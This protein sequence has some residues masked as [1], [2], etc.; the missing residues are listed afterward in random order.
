[1]RKLKCSLSPPETI[2]NQPRK[3][4]S[5][6]TLSAA[7]A[8]LATPMW[9]LFH[10]ITTILELSCTLTIKGPSKT[11]RTRPSW[12]WVPC[13]PLRTSPRLPTNMVQKKLSVATEPTPWPGRGRSNS[14]RTRCQPRSRARQF[15]SKTVPRWMWTTSSSAL[16]TSSTT[17]SWSKKF[18]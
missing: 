8:I 3:S 13:F 5:S 14:R 11:T 10:A 2:L 1:M 7:L 9:R 16:A 12:S 4:N 6:I 15:T 17:R 18:A